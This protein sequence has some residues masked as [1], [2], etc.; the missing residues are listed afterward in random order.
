MTESTILAISLFFHL[1]ATAVWI[2]GLIITTILIWPEARRTL[3]GNPA[4]YGFLK[5]VRL[6]FT[7]YSNLSLVVL[8]V[9]GMFQMALNENYEGFLDLSNQW[10]VVIFVKHIA[11][12]GMVICGAV[13]QY[14]V[15]PALERVSILLE[16]QKGDVAEWERLRRREVRLTW[17]NVLLGVAVL[18]FS[19]WAG[20]L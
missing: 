6:R 1:L 11:I 13:L 15:F 19:A 16:R 20:S 7:P 8:I 17:V 5:R 14:A 4:L 9:T 10:S 3:A 12:V 2:G 18:G